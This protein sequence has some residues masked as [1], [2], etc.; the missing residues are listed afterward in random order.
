MRFLL[1]LAPLSYPS[2]PAFSTSFFLLS[3]KLQ[4]PSKWKSMQAM[5]R[6]G[7]V[8]PP[9][10][11][12]EGLLPSRYLVSLCNLSVRILYFCVTSSILAAI[13]KKKHK[14]QSE[15]KACKLERGRSW[16]SI[17]DSPVFLPEPL[18]SLFC[19]GSPWA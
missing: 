8:V 10:S 2:L 13:Q 14:Q 4:I 18:S 9:D 1:F 3:S 17:Q 12:R 5:N 15:F 16:Q 7:T 6:I 11:S 19:S